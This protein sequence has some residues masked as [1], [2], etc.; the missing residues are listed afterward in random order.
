MS[1]NI[2]FVP[3]IMAEVE[4]VCFFW[5]V[6]GVNNLPF[7]LCIWPEIYSTLKLRCTSVYFVCIIHT[8]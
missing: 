2:N 4:L 3:L 8:V 6:I 1:I 7:M 5:K